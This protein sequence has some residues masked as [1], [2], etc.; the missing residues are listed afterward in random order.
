MAKATFVIPDD[1]MIAMRRRAGNGK[2]SEFVARAIRH[3]LLALDLAT[4]AAYEATNSNG[5][6]ADFETA[7]DGDGEI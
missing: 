7:F 5:P 3:E 1:L 6:E 4:I 2:Q